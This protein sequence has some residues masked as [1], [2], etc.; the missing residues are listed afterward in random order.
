M[1]AKESYIASEWNDYT[2][3][4]Y[5]ARLAEKGTALKGS[6]HEIEQKVI[7]NQ[8]T[9]LTSVNN[10]PLAFVETNSI[11]SG[12][13]SKNI[14]DTISSFQSQNIYGPVDYLAKSNPV[15]RPLP[16][17]TAAAPYIPSD[18]NLQSPANSKPFSS[19]QYPSQ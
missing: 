10:K 16:N 17:P 3:D 18:T 12:S 7:S 5:V 11:S 1:E 4:P 15:S 8:K 13:E 14:Q 19:N 6:E 2:L 9:T